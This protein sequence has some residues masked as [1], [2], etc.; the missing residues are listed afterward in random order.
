MSWTV[1]KLG[2]VA[3]IIMGQAPAGDTYNTEGI[4]LPLVAGAADL[5]EVNPTCKKYTSAP[6][7]VSQEGDIIMCI[8]ATIGDLNWADGEYALGRGVAGI[9]V[10][11]QVD[12]LY[13]WYWLLANKSYFLSKGKGA[14]FLQISRIDIVEAL[15][16]LPPLE[17]QKRIAQV[18][19]KAD[20][21][22]QKDRLLLQKYDQLLQSVFLYMFGDP[23]KNEKGWEI[24]TVANVV[25]TIVSGTSYGG[26]DRNLQEDE[27]GVLKISAVTSGTFN[28]NE[29]K[30][31]PKSLILKKTIS[32]KKGDL[33]FSRA[34][35]RELVAA[36]CIVD[37]DY[38]L[39]F[40]PDK[41]WKINLKPTCNPFYFRFLLSHAEFRNGLTKTA[42]GTSGSML[43][44][45]MEKLRQ[46]ELPL[47]DICTQNKFGKAVEKVEEVKSLHLRSSG[48]SVLLFQSLLQKAFKGELQLKE[49]EAV[50]ESY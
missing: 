50:E 2:A 38:P 48:H 34:N 44:I 15:I 22:R 4:G 1:T 31:V 7:K 23:V 28:P 9:R 25:E 30:A 11:K 37:K 39:L 5:G 17:E 49:V 19:D 27:L 32:P 42:T 33:L 35:T 14:T 46:L 47:P 36:T 20:R 40:L 16:P 43:N 13:L 45:S 10:G 6:G 3:Q 18:L 21:L 12:K 26:E 29:Y 41:L 24:T 8:R